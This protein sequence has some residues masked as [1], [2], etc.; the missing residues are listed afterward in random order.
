MLYEVITLK[1]LKSEPTEAKRCQ[2]AVERMALARLD[3]GFVFKSGGRTVFR[4]TAAQPLH[5]RLA[6]LWPPAVCEGMLP[7][8]RTR[9]GLRIHGLAGSPQK[10]QSRAD[11]MLFYVN[12]RA[13]QDRVLASA[14]RE[15]YKGRLLASYN[16]V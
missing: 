12:G 13:V 1:F 15:A 2:E 11:R 10:A 16:F 7:F 9:D 6:I 5:S 8:D 4:F 14:A 3:V